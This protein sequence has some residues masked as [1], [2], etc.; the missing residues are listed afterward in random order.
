MSN[1]EDVGPDGRCV[2]LNTQ[3]CASAGASGREMPPGLLERCVSGPSR[4][5][6]RD[7]LGLGTVVGEGEWAGPL[8]AA[9][10]LT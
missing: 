9:R 2:G 8:V 5:D 4:E 3:C 10:P 1:E 6:P 7:R